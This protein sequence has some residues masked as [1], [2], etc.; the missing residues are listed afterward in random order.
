MKKDKVLKARVSDSEFEYAEKRWTAANKSMSDFLR[1]LLVG[2]TA[3]RVAIA[4]AG[5][6]SQTQIAY[7]LEV[8][9][10]LV[11][12]GAKFEDNECDNAV[13][14]LSTSVGAVLLRMDVEPYHRDTPK[15]VDECFSRPS[16]DMRDYI[17]T[18]LAKLQELATK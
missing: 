9:A 8:A 1:G 15:W 5:R 4:S 18:D 11:D 14:W 10:V 2:S 13:Y 7:L 3:E 16:R 12:R 17:K 6:Y